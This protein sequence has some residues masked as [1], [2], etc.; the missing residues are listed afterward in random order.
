MPC[1]FETGILEPNFKNNCFWFSQDAESAWTQP[2]PQQAFA[3]PSG[4]VFVD[5][6]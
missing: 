5:L 6:A 2:K 1:L 4:I 3:D